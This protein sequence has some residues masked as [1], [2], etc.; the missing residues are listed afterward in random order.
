MSNKPMV[1]VYWAH[2]AQDAHSV[3]GLLKSEGIKADVLG[4][5]LAGATH[6]VFLPAASP[7]VWVAT[8]DE[9]RALAVI[10]AWQESRGDETEPWTCGQ[11]GEPVE[12]NFDICWKCEAPRVS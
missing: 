6:G 12:G 11:C 9:N 7:R 2:N 4:E 10:A 1:E 3:A 8:S 5:L